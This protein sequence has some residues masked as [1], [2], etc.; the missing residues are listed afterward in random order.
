MKKFAL[1]LLVLALTVQA[2][3]AVN[4]TMTKGTGADANKVTVSYGCTAGEEVRAFALRIA[5]T[6]KIF[7]VGSPVGLNTNYY[8]YPGSIQFAV[9]GSGE[10]YISSLGT[11]VAAQDANGGVIEMASLYAA[12]DV[13][14][15]SAP[16][17][18]AGP[19]AL[20]SFRVNCGL[21]AQTVTLSLDTQ[22]GGVVLK[23]PNVAPTVSLPAALSIC[24]STP[25]CWACP[26]Q[27]VGDTNGSGSITAADLL[28]V[29]NAF[30]TNSTS[31]P[32][33]TGVGQYNCCADFNH[34]NSVTAADLL[35]LKQHFGQTGLGTCADKSCP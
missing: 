12:G 21:T 18:G 17:T 10:T 11:P 30:G 1:A 22:R 23:D 14:H 9:A 31:F 5:V 34:S 25:P 2:G 19:Y 7:S 24:A 15:P 6:G 4:I 13:N 28:A 8:V 3:A 20:L 29:K 26:A 16:P 27:P 35:I 32:H 33:G